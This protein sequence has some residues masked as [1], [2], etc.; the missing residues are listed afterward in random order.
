[1]YHDLRTV[2]IPDAFLHP[3]APMP[4]HK[5]GEGATYDGTTADG[6]GHGADHDALIQWHLID[7]DRLPDNGKGPLKETR[8]T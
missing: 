3:E 5:L 6:H 2:L 7:G 8:T 4:A 1:M